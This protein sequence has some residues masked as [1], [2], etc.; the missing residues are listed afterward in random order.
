MKECWVYVVVDCETPG[1][2]ADGGVGGGCG[3]V[4]IA[5]C[6]G[7]IMNAHCETF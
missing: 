4:G 3:C 6:V 5:A 1:T 7:G 2:V